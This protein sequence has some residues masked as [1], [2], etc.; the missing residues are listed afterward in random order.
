MELPFWDD[1]SFNKNSG[2]PI[3]TLWESGA[4]IF[5]N[6][7]LGIDP[8]SINVAT[9][10]GLDSIGNPYNVTDVLAKGFADRLISRKINLETIIPEERTTVYLS[11]YYQIKGLGE[12]PDKDDNFSVWFRNNNGTWENVFTAIYAEELDP[13]TFNYVTI[14]I[15]EE[16]FY[17]SE[18]QFKFENFARL[19]GPYDMWHL[20]YI[21]LNSGRFA[22]ERSIPDRTVSMNFTSIFQGYN[23]IPIT[24]LKDTA[25]SITTAQR[26]KLYG[27]LEN[28]FQPFRYT[29]QAVLT[30][31]KDNQTETK[32]FLIE[33]DAAPINPENGSAEIIK[34]FQILN[35]SLQKKFPHDSLNLNADSIQVK[36]KFGMNSGDD[37]PLVYLPKYQPINFLS[38]DSSER[39]FTL[40]SYYAKDD[41]VAEFGA[42]LNQSGAELAVQFDLL[43]SAPDTLIAVDIYFPQF[44]DQNNRTLTLKV[45]NNADTIPGTTLTQQTITVNRSASNQFH[46]Y[47][48]ADP[49]LITDKFYVGWKQTSAIMVPAGLDKN[50]NSGKSIFFNITGS[51]DQ[52][53]TFVGSLMIR[54]VFGKGN[55]KILTT[56]LWK[57]RGTRI[58]PNP[59][60]DNFSINKSAQIISIIDVSGRPAS[61]KLIESEN[62]NII[63]L[64]SPAPGIYMI[65]W[66]ENG[67]LYT[68]KLIAGMH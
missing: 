33:D 52:D 57:D 6:D 61:F 43:K 45:W 38:N 20:D 40:S 56:G 1:F 11:F 39:I 15:L 30:T 26:I 13:G 51:W 28:N 68:S 63:Q 36:M 16:R 54:P 55:G 21:Y 8:P 48:L 32:S 29:T 7:G 5:V 58:W 27:L 42:G 59:A 19:S 50:N 41:G 17:H 34:P 18:F 37:N 65:R 25:A 62:S 31:I 46:R 9:F 4:R 23:S 44:G 66:F 3:D 2:V 60:S 53:S 24:H 64:D 35:L 12:M 10:D 67:K 22:G 49:V 47:K 14:P